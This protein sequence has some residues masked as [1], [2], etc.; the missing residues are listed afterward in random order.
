M[1]E[2]KRKIKNIISKSLTVFNFH[3]IIQG[4]TL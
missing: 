2:S 3:T 4:L 1:V